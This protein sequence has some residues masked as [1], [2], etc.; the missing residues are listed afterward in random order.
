MIIKAEPIGKKYFLWAA[1]LLTWIMKRRF[2]RMKIYEAELLKDHSYVLMSNH[3]SFWDGF[4]AGYLCYH[5]IYK[6]NPS[7][8]GFYIMSVEAQMKK[9]WWLKKLGCFSVAPGTVSVAE[10]LDYAAELLNEPGNIFLMWPQGN[11]ESNH[12]S[13]IVMKPGIADIMKRV[14]GNC[15]LFWSSNFIEYFES[16]KPSVYFH[17]LNC[18]TKKDFTFEKLVA[19]V[20]AHH[21]RSMKKQF[22][23][24]RED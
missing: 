12:V 4:W 6:T 15:Q 3:F 20:N 24:T 2:N 1:K 17:L 21:R 14:T 23:F 7:V 9:H 13:K 22:R 16:L 19:D 18:G 11:L 8:K 5:F 10:S